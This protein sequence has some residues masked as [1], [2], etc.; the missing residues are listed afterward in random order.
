[1][2]RRL[3]AS[4]ILILFGGCASQGAFNDL[5]ELETTGELSPDVGVLLVSTGRVNSGWFSQLPFV[6]YGVY[7]KAGDEEVEKVAFLPA[8]AGFANKLGKGKYGFIHVR[9]L[10]AGSYYLV[11]QKGRGNALDTP[12]G[13]LAVL[14]AG[15][16]HYDS[17]GQRVGITLEFKITAGSISY[18][19]EILT[20]S[21]ELD[22]DAIEL[23]DQFE[24]D[25]GHMKARFPQLGGVALVKQ[26]PNLL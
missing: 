3:L 8:E 21:R 7:R 1:M 15:M 24:R 14:P 5:P 6:S 23:S 26:R 12:V 17:Q 4:L 20:I 19:G 13:V 2:T 18:L 25:F 9:E 10:Q 16:I 11:G 22:S